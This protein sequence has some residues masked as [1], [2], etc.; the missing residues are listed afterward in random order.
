MSGLARR[1]SAG[2]RSAIWTPPRAVRPRALRAP[3]RSAD[4]PRG[5]ACASSIDRIRG[6][7]GVTM[8]RG[9]AGS[10]GLVR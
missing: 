10:D 6:H 1:R 4:G 3:Q 7:A 2:C 8:I 5:R 9:P